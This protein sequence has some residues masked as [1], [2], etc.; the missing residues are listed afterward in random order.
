MRKFLLFI[1]GL[2]AL[3]ILLI[4]LGPLVL[5]GLGVWLLYVVFKKFLKSDSIVGKIAWVIV[6]LIVLSFTVVN[7][8]AVIG[9][10][11]AYVLYLI[12]KNWR[13]DQ[14]DP[15]VKTTTE[16]EDPF[17]NFERQWAELN[18]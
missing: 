18:H 14:T 15:V 1:A 4:N 17:T 8:Y 12:F 16:D 7:V 11:A 9:I 5:L 2:A 10:A 3:M 13:T 6:G